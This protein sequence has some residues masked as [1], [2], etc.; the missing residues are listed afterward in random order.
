MGK[1]VIGI[2]ALYHDSACCILR[3]GKVIAAAQEERFTRNKHD[4]SM[5]VNAFKY[6][7]KEANI[8]I[9]DI[10]YLAYYEK[11]L[12]K[13]SRQI[14]SGYNI[15]D[16]Q[17]EEQLDSKRPEREIREKLG[18][19]GPIEYVGHHLSHASSSYYFS[20]Y[21][22]A[23]ILTID[24][25]GEWETTTYGI[26]CG[27]EIEIFEQ[28]EFPNSIGLLYSTF[29]SYLGFKVNDGEYKVMGL[30]P[31][32]EAKYVEQIK[33]LIK[34]KEF[35]QY[36]LNMEYFD[37]VNGEKMYSDKFISLFGEPAR[38]PETPIEKFYKDVA[39]SLQVVVEEIV[40]SKIRYLRE[41][42]GLDSLCL[43]G[44]VAL[45]CVVNGKII[46]EKIFKNVF[47]QPAASDA[48]TA[49]GAAAY[50]Y[51]KYGGSKAKIIKLEN[52]FLGPAYSGKNIRKVLDNMGLCYHD[53]MSV[54]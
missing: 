47:I 13:L 46:A 48:G 7:L 33:V 2:S 9:D 18:Y 35:G 24:G 50:T 38:I 17:L 3:D 54:S 39:K 44:G 20:G 52:V 37:F 1:Y 45:N 19:Q 11:P 21:E 14:W 25:V 16:E 23:A 31:Y 8:T 15:F 43:A 27:N 40:L 5:P 12:E 26:G 51:L 30:A 42:T 49:L 34:N 4:P 6:C 22:N 36:E 10:S 28:V 29:T 41:I 32:G 53:S